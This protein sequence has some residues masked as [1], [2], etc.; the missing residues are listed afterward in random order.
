MEI[1]EVQLQELTW[2][3]LLRD[4]EVQRILSVP[5]N[6]R[7]ADCG[8]AAPPSWASLTYGVVLSSHAAGRHRSLGTHISRVLSL[9]LDKWDLPDY[10]A[11][12]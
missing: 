12:R 7:C 5:G 4:E 10:A 11:W 3:R 2:P 6:D 1:S 8:H 9:T